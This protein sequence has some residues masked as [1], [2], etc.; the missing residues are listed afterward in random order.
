[1]RQSAGLTIIVLVAV[2]FLLVLNGFK[3]AD[4]SVV[5]IVGC[6]LSGNDAY[7]RV[8]PREYKPGLVTLNV[9]I[10]EEGRLAA[11]GSRKIELLHIP[12]E[13]LSFR[14][15]LTGNLS[16]HET[17]QVVVDLPGNE[18]KIATLK[19]PDVA[20]SF[21][22]SV[23]FFTR[24]FNPIAEPKEMRNQVNISGIPRNMR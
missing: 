9:K 16:I 15:P 14:V 7:F 8:F 4:K 12:S 24:N 21:N 2:I 17:Y 22:S 11:L 18:S 3:I 23:Q 6:S 1:M 13:G 10:Y 20:V 5:E 19:W